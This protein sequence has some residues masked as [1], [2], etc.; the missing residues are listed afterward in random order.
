MT[1]G[2]GMFAICA[3]ILMQ[4]LD[5]VNAGVLIHGY[6]VLIQPNSS[7]AYPSD[8]AF[9]T[10]NFYSYASPVGY[11]SFGWYVTPAKS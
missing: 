5:S 7:S 3:C 11:L 10:S 2:S 6:S 9:S 8:A 1:T 4:L